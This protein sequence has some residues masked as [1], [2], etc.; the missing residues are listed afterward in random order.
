M[1]EIHDLRGVPP[2]DG[3]ALGATSHLNSLKPDGSKRIITPRLAPGRFW[4]RRR[5]VAY[6]LVVLFVALPFM[7][8]DTHPAFL[9]DVIHRQFWVAGHLFL[10]S[11]TVL[12]MLLGFVLLFGLVGTTAAFGRVWCGWVCPQTVYMEFFF[13]PLDRMFNTQ[14][15]W[16]RLL[17]KLLYGVLS[18]LLAN[19]FLSYFVGTDALSEWVWRAPSA[20]PGA[21]ALVVIVSGM[22]LFDFGFFREQMCT[23]ACPYARLQSVM[24]DRQTLIIGYDRGRGEPR[25]KGKQRDGAGDCIDCG[26]CVAVCPTGI[27]IRRGL[28]LECI[29]C[30][31][32]IDACDDIMVQLHKPTGLIRYDTQAALEPQFAQDTVPIPTWRR[33]L[34][35]RIV[36]YGVIVLIAA[37][38]LAGSV[39]AQKSVRMKL[40][41][42][43][44][45]PYAVMGE[46]VQ[47]H[48]RVHVTSRMADTLPVTVV[49]QAIDPHV[50]L[51]IVSPQ[52]IITLPPAGQGETSMFVSAPT[53]AFHNG[54][55][56]IT[57]SLQS[58]DGRTIDSAPFVLLGPKGNP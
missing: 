19:L 49:A 15:G 50:G 8:V 34:R 58:S 41:R 3:N 29:G 48:V 53:H 31:Q 27:D 44:G 10:P 42:G 43:Q 6:G 57:V 54:K 36:A 4:N 30:A 56:V 14:I 25:R 28:Q 18:F 47:N 20:H 23:V 11:D 51:S 21:F 5:M 38:C 22:M 9:L 2:N 1:G 33:M 32:C 40:L 39:L 45:R 7:R 55:L 35:P 52:A 37:G 24:I 16:Q 17:R 12:L 26:K 46:H 13:R